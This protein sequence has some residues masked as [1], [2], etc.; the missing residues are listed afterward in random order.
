[1]LSITPNQGL[2]SAPVPVVITGA[3]FFGLPAARLGAAVP[4]TVSAATADAITGTVP[5]GFTPGVYGLTVTNPDAQFGALSPAYL[6]FNPATPDTTLDASGAYLSTYGPAAPGMLG[7]D[8]HVQVIFFEVPSTNTDNLYFR[9][10]D[11]DTGGGGLLGEN[12]DV[13][14]VSV[15]NLW[16][17]TMTYTLRGD[18]GYVASARLAHPA[19]AGIDAGVQLGQVAIGADS[20]YHGNWEPVFGPFAAG[21]GHLAG[22]CR[23]FKLVVQGALGND[24]NY[25]NVALSTAADSN[26]PPAQSRVFAYSWT[27]PLSATVSPRPPLFPYVPAAASTFEQHNWDADY[28]GGTITLRTPLRDVSVPGGDISGDGNAASSAHGVLPGEDG[29]TWTTTFNFSSAA[30]SWNDLTFWVEDGAG[31]D[32]AI[33]TAPTIGSPP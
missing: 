20:G 6:A 18:G 27:F 11:A 2:L 24:G 8:D 14:E 30:P 15:P 16:D 32:L 19:A 26:T 10:F 23:V 29:A 9:I 13:P 17:T 5:A 25:Y 28:S 33:F 1:V 7:D 12:V 21:Q 31:G 3:N 4:I 22:S